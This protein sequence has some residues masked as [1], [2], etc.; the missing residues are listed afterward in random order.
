MIAV[1]LQN[2]NEYV[3]QKSIWN[4][5]WKMK[6]TA[7]RN[8]QPTDND[9]EL[10]N[11]P[12]GVSN[13]TVNISWFV[14]IFGFYTVYSES[15]HIC[16]S[17]VLMDFCSASIAAYHITVDFFVYITQPLVFLFTLRMSV[18]TNP[19]VV[20]NYRQSGDT[21][22]VCIGWDLVYFGKMK[23]L[24]KIIHKNFMTYS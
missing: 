1:H 11:D 17:E 8:Y 10:A 18:S 14:I 23:G 21:H 20:F 4:E 2:R 19:L 9:W 22:W 24:G 5:S 3:G 15:E 6:Q 7:M 12:T 16:S 13:Q